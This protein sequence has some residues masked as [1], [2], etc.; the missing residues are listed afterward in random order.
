MTLRAT[1][2]FGLCMHSWPSCQSKP[3]NVVS[4]MLQDYIRSPEG[5]Y[6]HIRRQT[7]PADLGIVGGM[8]D[9]VSRSPHFVLHSAPKAWNQADVEDFFRSIEWTDVVV[10]ARR[11]SWSKGASPE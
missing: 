1:I 8:Q 2:P 5:F 4:G 7:G 9:D 6:L 10:I 11:K 3:A